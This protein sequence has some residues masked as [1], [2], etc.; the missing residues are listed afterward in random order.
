MEVETYDNR[1]TIDIHRPE[2]GKI[3]ETVIIVRYIRIAP[4]VTTTH[5]TTT[6]KSDT[7]SP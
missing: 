1:L 3:Q 6:L 2:T 5:A 4:G 7:I